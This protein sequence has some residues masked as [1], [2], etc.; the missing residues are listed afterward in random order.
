VNKLALITELHKC[1]IRQCA[2]AGKGAGRFKNW[3]GWVDRNEFK[4]V[5]TIL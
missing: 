3:H 1:C 2:T 5:L 4:C